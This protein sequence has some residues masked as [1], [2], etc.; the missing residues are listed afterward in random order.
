[1]TTGDD[2]ARQRGLA[3][4]RAEAESW[5]N[6]LPRTPSGWKPDYWTFA[7]GADEFLVKGLTRCPTLYRWTIG[8]LLLHRERRMYRR[9]SGLAPL[10][11]YCGQFDRNSLILEHITNATSLRQVLPEDLPPGFFDALADSVRQLHDLGVVHLDLRHRK[12]VLVT[13]EGPRIVDLESAV[14][15]GRNA[16]SRRYLLPLLAWIDHSAVLKHRARYAPEETTDDDH[17]ILARYERRL[18]CWGFGRWLS[19]MRKVLLS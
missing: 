7:D 10:P 14:Y 19:A 5:S 18:A 17:A 2:Y 3:W 9:L 13:A 4:N 12:N 15:V 11:E 8:R 1:M 6:D 16:L